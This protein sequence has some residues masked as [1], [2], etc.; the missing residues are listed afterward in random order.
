MTFGPFDTA[1]GL[2]ERAHHLI[3]LILPTDD[4]NVTAYNLYGHKTLDDAYGN[5]TGSGVGGA[6]P[7]EFISNVGRN[8]SYRSPLIVERGHGRL[9]SRAQLRR[10]SRII[11][12]LDDYDSLTQMPSDTQALYVRVQE[13]AVTAGGFREVLGAV[14]TGDPVLGPIYVVP[15]RSFFRGP[16]GHLPL[17]GTAPGGTTATPGSI[18]PLNEDSQ[19][20]RMMHIILP[21]PG[22]ITI[23]NLDPANDL[24]YTFSL[25]DT[26][27]SLAAGEV[28]VRTTPGVKE[29]LLAGEGVNPVPFQLDVTVDL[30]VELS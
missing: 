4:P 10:R 29:I 5:P 16:N 11:F 28:P 6:G 17:G 13:Y 21:R 30:G 22:S 24:Y 9:T 20:P 19:V 8:S 27:L 3:D 23:T 2:V 12:D 18:A 15:P 14:D 25:D 26:V 1:V 7:V